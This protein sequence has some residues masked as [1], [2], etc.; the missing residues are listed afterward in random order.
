[1]QGLWNVH[2]RSRLNL[3]ATPSEDSAGL[4][5]DET[6]QIDCQ[7]SS[8]APQ[9]LIPNLEP[10][11]GK[12]KSRS[13]RDGSTKRTKLARSG[14]KDYSPPTTRLS[15][16][17]GVDACVERLLELVAMPLCH[18]E[19]YLH[20]GVQ[21]PRGVL[22][23]G[24]P[25]CGKTM[26]ANAMAGVSSAFNYLLYLTVHLTGTQGTVYQHFCAVHRLRH[27]RWIR[28]DFTWYVWRSKGRKTSNLSFQYLRMIPESSS[29]SPFHRR[30]RRD[31]SKARE[32]TEG[33][34][35][36]NCCSISHMHGWSVLGSRIWL[37]S[38]HIILDIS[39]EKTDN[40]PIVVIGA[41]NRPDALDA[42]LRRA[43]RFDHEI[44]MGVPDQDARE[45]WV[46]NNNVHLSFES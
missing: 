26:L 16:L 20:T 6:R 15:D 7:V 30:N 33:N 29:L 13:A 46:M 27:V 2:R 35:E 23:H 1:M 22:L 44:S 32:C 38:T 25:G 3:N 9:Q 8:T 10:S 17:G 5:I 41:T 39:W 42:A 19:I 31:Y 4:P 45:Q 18:P 24:P 40:K 28:K 14:D 34:G 11:S 21:P 43:G 36:T 12:R 37:P